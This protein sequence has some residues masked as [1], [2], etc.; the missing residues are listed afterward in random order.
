MDNA[1]VR[2]TQDVLDQFGVTEQAGLS[3]S[4]VVSSRQKHG[5]NGMSIMSFML[6]WQSI[7]VLT[8]YEYSTPR[9]PPNATLGA[10]L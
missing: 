9:R 10:H 4:Q 1:Y 3:E 6:A 8:R 2:S 5:R 7:K